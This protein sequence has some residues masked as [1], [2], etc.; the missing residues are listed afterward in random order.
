M[1]GIGFVTEL[2]GWF[3]GRGTQQMTT[4]GGL[5]WSPVS[6]LSDT[7]NRFHFFSDTHGY[8][9]GD[10][11]FQYGMGIVGNEDEAPVAREIWVGAAYPN[12][13]PFRILIPYRL[14]APA[15]VTL[16]VFDVRGRAVATVDLGLRPAGPNELI[17][18]SRSG[19]GEALPPGVY[20]YRFQ[21]GNHT[22]TGRILRMAWEQ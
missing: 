9:V 19:G 5:T 21:A 18:D 11:V 3:G 15:H 22:A 14:P 10:R 13:F 12:P 1:Q 2:I 20:L 17:W 7:M 8:A 6:Y 16:E 4:D